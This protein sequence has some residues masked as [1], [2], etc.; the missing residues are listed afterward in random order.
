[1]HCPQA[2]PHLLRGARVPCSVSSDC[3]KIERV[4]AVRARHACEMH[5]S[6][7]SSVVDTLISSESPES[8]WGTSS[9]FCGQVHCGLL[10]SADISSMSASHKRKSLYI[11]QMTDGIQCRPRH[12]GIL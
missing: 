6:M 5:L 9:T 10:F 8:V 11:S 2:P 1:M 4:R 7:A 12:F 3:S